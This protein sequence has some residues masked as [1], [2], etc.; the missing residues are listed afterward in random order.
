MKA[1]EYE[2]YNNRANWSFNDIKYSVENFTNWIYE[3]EIAKR[4]NA[5]SKILDLGTAAGEKVLK[6]FPNCSEILGTDFSKEMIKAANK[7][8]EEC[9]RKNIKFK[10]MNNLKMD[11]PDNYFD[12]V[13][14]RHT[15]TD[16]KQIYKTLKPGGYLI[17]RGVDK[18][19]CW[20]LKRLFNRG[21]G[22][23]DT[24]PISLIDYEAVLEAGF[25]NVE[26][27]PLHVIEYYKSKEDLY[28]LL[29]KVP[30]LDD[31]SEIKDGKY[32]R[33]PIENDIFEKY[34]AENT[35]EKGIKLIR[36]YYGIVAQK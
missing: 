24:K 18:L 12:L 17:I 25:K 27:I 13:T 14:A 29:L 31:F 28:A 16:P 1:N 21:Q 26:L 5:N 6:Y 4:S 23:T 2:Y 9:G 8:L 10:V 30:I 19:D 32:E 3:D 7:N 36:R 11:T 34:V 15:V 20:N 35:T 22:F 33:V